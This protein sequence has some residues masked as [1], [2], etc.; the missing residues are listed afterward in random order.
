MRRDSPRIWVTQGAGASRGPALP[1]LELQC[2]GLRSHACSRPRWRYGDGSPVPGLLDGERPLRR[3]RFRPAGGV[4][5]TNSQPG[6]ERATES[7]IL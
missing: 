6:C 1:F 7:W 5:G 3:L 2:C 4:A